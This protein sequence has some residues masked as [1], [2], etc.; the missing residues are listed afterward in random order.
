MPGGRPEDMSQA[1]LERIVKVARSMQRLN[2]DT[3][4]KFSSSLSTEVCV[5]FNRAMGRIL[6][7]KAVRSQP[8]VFPYISLPEP[9]KEVVKETGEGAHWE[10]VEERKGGAEVKWKERRQWKIRNDQIYFYCQKPP[11]RLKI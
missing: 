9:M 6:F 3:M 7:D 5:E 8:E 10:E 11:I 1:S 2:T 4:D